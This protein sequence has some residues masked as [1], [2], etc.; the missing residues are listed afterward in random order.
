MPTR[1]SRAIKTIATFWGRRSAESGA[2]TGSWLGR[3]GGKTHRK[4]WRAEE[5]AVSHLV[6]RGYHI[7]ERN[8][9][10]GGGETDIVAEHRRRL[11]FVEV[12]S[13]REGGDMRPSS[14]VT[15]KKQ[16]QVIACGE[17]YIKSRGLDR[18]EVK[19]RY[20]IAEVYLDRDGR[21]RTVTVIEGGITQRDGRDRR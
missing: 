3:G 8:L 11:V 5:F 21:P 18:E 16:R 19:P 13:R 1:I 7:L 12:R 4:G 17:A 10:G 2:A 9:V 15:E 6:G 20:D 14:T